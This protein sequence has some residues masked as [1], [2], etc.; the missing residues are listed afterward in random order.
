MNE[1]SKTRS[2][3]DSLFEK[4]YLQGYGI[5]IGCGNDLVCTNAEPFDLKH[6][7]AQNILKHKRINSFDFVHS[8]HC[9]EHMPDPKNALEEW[10]AILKPGGYFVI[11]VP[12]EDLYEQRIW[13]SK[14][15][16]DHKA[17]FTLNDK[18]DSWSP[19]SF[20]LSKLITALPGAEIISSCLHN[21]NYNNQLAGLP[22]RHIAHKLYR[23]SFYKKKPLKRFFAKLITKFLPITSTVFEGKNA[24]PIDQSRGPAL[25]QIQV[26]ARKKHKYVM[27]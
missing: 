16:P 14:Y 26:I 2:V 18:S 10:W 11:V 20:N 7:D 5:D 22:R 4:T 17:T 24:Y 13:P 1:A 25:C 12:D 3:R 9:L 23:W 6:G 27:E 19:A 15:N 21:K 8:S